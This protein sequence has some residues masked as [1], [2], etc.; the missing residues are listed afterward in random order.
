MASLSLGFNWLDG[1]GIQGPELAATYASLEV[2]VG[3]VAITRVL[4][5]TERSV[6]DQIYVPLYPL[7]ESLASNW[8][9]YSGE[10]RIPSGPERYEFRQRHSLVNG[11]DGFVFPDL[12]VIPT[13]ERLQLQW[14]RSTKEDLDLSH[15]EFLAEGEDRVDLAVFQQCCAHLIEAVL[16]RLKASG[17]R[18]TYLHEEWASIRSADPEEVAF[19][20]TAAGCGWDPYDLDE[21]RREAMEALD[22]LG[23][24]RGEAVPAMGSNSPDSVIAS[25]TAVTQAFVSAR[26]GAG[27]FCGLNSIRRETEPTH[28][29]ED[30][31]TPWRAGYGMARRL[32]RALGLDGAPLGTA[33]ELARG[34]GQKPEELFAPATADFGAARLFDGVVSGDEG[35]KTSFLLRPFAETGRR[36]ALCRVLAEALAAPRTDAVLTQAPTERQQRNRAF[37]AE[38]LAPSS[39]LRE[40]VSNPVVHEDDLANLATAFGVSELVIGHQVENHGIARVAWP[41][42]F[43]QVNS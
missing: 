23:V 32:R 42:P 19:C 10:S 30:D 2:R 40:R 25:C 17:V 9:F 12:I 3:S 22:R 15:T 34:L 39:S 28:E 13:G 26:E 1:A 4:D 29:A 41:F 27:A 24:V 36:F 5:H 21:A 38:F 11:G 20:E 8:W 6:R 35:E 7:A 16:H 43:S 33:E 14:F 31:S 18:D 37:A